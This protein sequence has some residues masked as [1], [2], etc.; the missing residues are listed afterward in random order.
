MEGARCPAR[1]EV[2]PIFFPGRG[3]RARE[4][5]GEGGLVL[6]EPGSQTPP[7]LLAGMH[8]EPGGR[9]RR[10]REWEREKGKKG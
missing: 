5:N 7:P 8:T 1:R 10:E 2:A 9:R 3:L 4:A 6:I